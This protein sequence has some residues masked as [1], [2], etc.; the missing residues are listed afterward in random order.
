MWN[1][2]NQTS[3]HGARGQAEKLAEIF[4]LMKTGGT[5]WVFG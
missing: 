2:Q 4:G 3:S 5:F 1:C